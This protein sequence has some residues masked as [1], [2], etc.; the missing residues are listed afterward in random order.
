V[1][2][3]TI[4]EQQVLPLLTSAERRETCFADPNNGLL[5]LDLNLSCAPA[6][7]SYRSRY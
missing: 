6:P 7:M 1:L 4:L 3:D 2:P 5:Q